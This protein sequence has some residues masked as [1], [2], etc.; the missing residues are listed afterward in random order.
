MLRWQRQSSFFAGADFVSL[1]SDCNISQTLSLHPSVP[2]AQCFS[3]KKFAG[4]NESRVLI[5]NLKQK[6]KIKKDKQIAPGF[7]CSL[8]TKHSVIDTNLCWRECEGEAFKW[9]N[10]CYF[11]IL[12]ETPALSIIHETQ[13]GINTF[14]KNNKSNIR[15]TAKNEKKKKTLE[16]QHGL[17]HFTPSM[18]PLI[19]KVHLC[20]TKQTR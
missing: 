17:L 20:N 11:S 3:P 9:G 18:T 2:S 19:S 6:K 10:R 15:A 5:Y 13:Q 8:K 16:C 14:K 1:W 12:S 7:T 4:Q